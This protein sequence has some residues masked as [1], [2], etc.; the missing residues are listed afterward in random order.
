MISRHWKGVAKPGQADAYVRHL[1]NDT[2]PKLAAIPGFVQASI[3]RREVATG[4]EFQ[5]VT[6]WES[7]SAIVAFAGEEPEIAVV[8]ESVRAMMSTCDERVVHY[9]IADICTPRRET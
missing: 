8:P 1:K 4:T 2:F 5:I 9:E 3:L 7:L 6:I